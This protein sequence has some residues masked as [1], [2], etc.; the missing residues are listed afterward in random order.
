[1]VAGIQM[2]EKSLDAKWSSIGM[3][4]EYQ[5]AQPFEYLTNG[6]HLVVLCTD[7]VQMVCLVH[8]T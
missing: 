2:V 8:S 5:T 6:P 1:M 7:P 3:P 4:F